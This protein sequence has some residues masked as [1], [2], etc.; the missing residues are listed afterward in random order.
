MCFDFL[1]IGL[2]TPPSN[3]LSE[4]P[5]I[6]FHDTGEAEQ[7]NHQKDGKTDTSLLLRIEIEQLH[8]K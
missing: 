8:N 4:A 7:L 1:T 3:A 6:N 2:H 5:R